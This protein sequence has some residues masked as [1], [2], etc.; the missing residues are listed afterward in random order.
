MAGATA[1]RSRTKN[2]RTISASAH[3]GLALSKGTTRKKA[4]DA[5][6]EAD[7]KTRKRVRLAVIARDLGRSRFSGDRVGRLTAHI[8]EEPSRALGGDPL[9]PACCL[10]LT[11]IEHPYFTHHYVDAIIV[12][13]ERGTSGP[14][15]YQLTLR[16]Q[17]LL[18]SVD[19]RHRQQ[20]EVF[21]RLWG[22]RRTEK[23]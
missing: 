6:D 21:K 12:D 20:R 7:K 17:E 8:H 16:G 5:R 13:K 10:T 3:P 19:A 14:V 2:R 18:G 23:K 9:D 11:P 4:K 15:E 1:T 22:R